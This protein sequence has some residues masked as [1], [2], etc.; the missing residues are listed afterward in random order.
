MSGANMANAD[1]DE[2]NTS[3]SA[4]SSA[5][6]A[7]VTNTGSLAVLKNLNDTCA[8]GYSR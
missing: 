4:V 8:V 6:T 3:Q 5:V 2:R 7:C 1:A